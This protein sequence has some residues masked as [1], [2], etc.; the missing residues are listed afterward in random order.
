[1]THAYGTALT[2]MPPRTVRSL[3]IASATAMRWFS[4]AL[5][6]ALFIAGCA[7]VAERSATT[8]PASTCAANEP[9]VVCVESGA[10]RGVPQGETLAFKGVPYAKPPVG[11]LR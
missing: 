10:I 7:G 1:M 4:V 3:S 9:D 11:P 5:A 6:P 8:T 2:P